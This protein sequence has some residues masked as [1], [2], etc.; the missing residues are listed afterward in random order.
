M[1]Q[2]HFFLRQETSDRKVILDIDAEK[3]S[4]T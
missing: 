4:E 3:A 2:V 1:E